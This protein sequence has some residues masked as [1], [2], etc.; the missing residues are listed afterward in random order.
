MG[1]FS[2]IFDFTKF[3]RKD[4]FEAFKD[5]P[6]RL[7]TGGGPIETEVW[8]KILGRDDEPIH[9][10]VGGP[11]GSG[12]FGLGSGGFFDDY[13]EE[14]GRSK[15]AAV[16]TADVGE[17]LAAILGLYF[18]GTA[19]A[20]GFGGGA[21]GGTGAGAGGGSAGGGLGGG[22]GGSG[23]SGFSG[24][25]GGGGTGGGA[26]GGSTAVT[27]GGNPFLGGFGG[28]GGSSAPAV[29]AESGGWWNFGNIDWTDPNTYLN[30]QGMMPDMSGMSMG[31]APQQGETE[32]ERQHREE[33]MKQALRLQAMLAAQQSQQQPKT[34]GV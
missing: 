17:V 31:G 8:N 16:K 1:Y 5:D 11:Q 26:G 14:T 13:V 24:P 18:G 3:W 20:G 25:F 4:Q 34:R 29:P 7:L 23:F 28:G 10:A 32:A 27:G 33:L 12:F 30:M 21:G 15:S 22:A 19:L 2:D 6:W 9:N